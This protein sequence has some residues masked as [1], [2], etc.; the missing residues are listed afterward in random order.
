MAIKWMAPEVL[1]C[2]KYS[3]KADVWSYGIVLIEIFSYGKEPYEGIYLIHFSIEVYSVKEKN[4][5]W[6][7]LHK[8]GQ[9]FRL[10]FL[11]FLQ[12]FLQLCH[13]QS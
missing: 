11:G 5:F 3:T 7:Y 2:N 4:G 8:A 6:K 10:S 9:S 13:I 1:L 12:L